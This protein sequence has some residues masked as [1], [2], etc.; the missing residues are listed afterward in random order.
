M[1]MIMGMGVDDLM[2]RNNESQ[3]DGGF[4]DEMASI[5]KRLDNKTLDESESSGI[6]DDH[7]NTSL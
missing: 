2:I 1:E 7:D 4:I 5:S 3:I 6:P